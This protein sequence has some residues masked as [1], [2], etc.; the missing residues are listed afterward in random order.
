MKDN[1]LFITGKLA[2]KNLRKVLDCIEKKD[3]SYEIRNLNINVAALLTT[4]MIS[5]RIGDVSKFNR[6]ILPGKVRGDVE[7]L[8]KD[9]KVKIERGPDELKDL[10]RLFGGK[11]LKYDLSKYEV[12]IF[13]EITDAPNMTIEEILKQANYYRD[14][15]ADI[16]DIGCLPNQKFSHL[17][18]TIKELKKEDFY[19]SVDSHQDDE[20]ITGGKAGA[21]YLLSIK[22]DNFHI[23]DKVDSYPILIPQ[24]GDM[25]SLYTSIDKCI[26]MKRVFIADPILDPIN[27]GFTKSILR[28]KELRDKYPDIH[29][30]MGTGNVTELTHADTT[31]ITMTLMGII[32]ELK[33]N[34]ILTTEVS[35]HCKSVVK[36][37]DLA[38][39]IIL[40]STLNDTTPKHINS[41]LLTTHEEDP[42]KFSVEEIRE[43]Y[44]KV[45]D[46]NYRIVVNDDGVHLFNRDGLHCSVDPFDF[47]PHINVGDDT[48]HAFYLGVEL[49]RAQIAYQLGKN[50]EQDEELKW[51]CLVE[52]KLDNKLSFKKVGSTYRK[53][54]DS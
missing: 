11:P 36:E 28:Y 26:D 38:R 43:L 15:G 5:R 25:E 3:F 18:E 13:A 51:G 17:E 42:F 27:Y 4:D 40:A 10:P 53:K 54:N 31:G 9:L 39:R 37:N 7:K 24:D 50:Y 2:E 8:S 21:D 20:L 19:V 41:G 30:M 34:H 12:H 32:S 44:E 23:L 46:P 49:A 52:E 16:I 22:T 1:I 29:I 47:Y 48:G 35:P 14:N 33:I 45:K 6:I